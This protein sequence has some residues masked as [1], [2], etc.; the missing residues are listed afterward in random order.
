MSRLPFE[1]LLALRYLRPKR[2]FVSMITLISI[3]GVML[4]VAV[5]IIVISV[6]SGF[7][8]ELRDK[9]LGF[10][11]HLRIGQRQGRL[12]NYEKLAERIASHPEVRG[13]A[14]F[15]FGQVLVET[16]PESGESAFLAQWVRGVDP[17]L[18]EKVSIVPK[19]VVQGSFDVRGNRVIVG[20]GVADSLGLRVGDPLGIYSPRDLRKM[21]E[22]RSQ[23]NAEG[24]LPDDYVVAGI[25]DVGY[26][27][28]NA[29][30]IVTSLANAQDLHDLEDSVHGLMVMLKDPYQAEKVRGEL[31]ATLGHD[32]VIKTWAEE[33]SV[34]LDALIV[35][36]NVMFYLLF[37]IVIVAAFGITSALITFVVQK[38]REIGVLKALGGTSGQIVWLFLSQSLVVGLLG[39]LSGF[40][41]GMLAVSYRNE[42][43][44]LMNRWTGFE[45]FP[46]RIYNFAE[47]PALI[48]P[49]DI[50]VICGGSLVI[51]LLAGL[52]PAW[53]A[54]RLKPVEA[55]RHE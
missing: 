35:E 3:I 20:R 48:D 29:S 4:G 13:V 14:P 25:F 44:R 1:L 6:M 45:L 17:K 5:L 41:L 16:Q 54:G 51:C 2:T 24:V 18:E 36:K 40:G 38:T 30:F 39:V 22:T 52:L 26:Y 21:K 15:V 8:R 55:L 9:I 46:A 28:Y 49:V 27:E 7:D 50:A 43:L 32:L 42:F 31:R 37:F 19:S 12:H 34:F 11:A 47:L 10:N 33:N 23:D 53:N